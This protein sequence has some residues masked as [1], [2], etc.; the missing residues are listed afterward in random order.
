MYECLVKGGV[1]KTVA[2]GF[3]NHKGTAMHESESGHPS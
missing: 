3:G 2:V 1:V